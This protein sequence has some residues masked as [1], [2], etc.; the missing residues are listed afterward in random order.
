MTIDYWS[1]GLAITWDRKTWAMEKVKSF[2]DFNN[3]GRE[4]NNYLSDSLLKKYRRKD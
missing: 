4:G 3:G 1:G 2:M